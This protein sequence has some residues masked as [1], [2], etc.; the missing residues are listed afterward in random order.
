M[1]MTTPPP[2]QMPPAEI[3]KRLAAL[4]LPG[5]QAHWH[6]L[7]DDIAQWVPTLLHWEEQERNQRGLERRLRSAKLGQFKA[8]ADFDWQWP[9]LLYTS[10]SPRD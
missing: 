5:L 8:L 2:D 1:S 7:P 6:E 10:P 3:N 9:C 4:K